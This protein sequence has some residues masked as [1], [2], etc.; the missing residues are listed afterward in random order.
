MTLFD[1]TYDGPRWT[2]GLKFR[3]VSY[4]NVPDGWIIH[5]GQ[6]HPDF[7]FGTIDYPFDLG[8]KAAS[9]DMVLVQKPANS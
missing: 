6:E 9:M 8:E 7:K 5:S 2:Y 4:A 3:P 1:D